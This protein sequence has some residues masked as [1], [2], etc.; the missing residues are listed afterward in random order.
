MVLGL[1]VL[2]SFPKLSAQGIF[3]TVETEAFSNGAIAGGITVHRSSLWELIDSQCTI[4]KILKHLAEG[5]IDEAYEL[6]LTRIEEDWWHTRDKININSVYDAF[7]EHGQADIGVELLVHYAEKKSGYAFLENI[8]KLISIGHS[9]R[10]FDLVKKMIKRYS[11]LGAIE[12]LSS[13]FK[14]AGEEKKAFEL[15]ATDL[16]HVTQVIKQF[17]AEEKLDE[18]YEY[19]NKVLE[20]HLNEVVSNQEDSNRQPLILPDNFRMIYHNGK[21]SGKYRIVKIS[22]QRKEEIQ[23]CTSDNTCSGSTTVPLGSFSIIRNHELGLEHLASVFPGTFFGTFTPSKNTEGLPPEFF[24]WI[25]NDETEQ[26]LNAAQKKFEESRELLTEK[27]IFKN[28]ISNLLEIAILAKSE[29]YYK[30]IKEQ[31]LALNPSHPVKTKNP[32]ITKYEPYFSTVKLAEKKEIRGSIVDV[33]SNTI[34]VDPDYIGNNP[35]EKKLLRFVIESQLYELSQR[36]T[37]INE[38]PSMILFDL[39]HVL[40]INALKKPNEHIYLF[41]RHPYTLANDP[42]SKLEG[43]YEKTFNSVSITSDISELNEFNGMLIHELTH[44]VMDILFHTNARPYETGYAQAE[45][46]TAMQGMSDYIEENFFCVKQKN[47]DLFSRK[48]LKTYEKIKM[49]RSFYEY[50]QWDPEYI[51]RLTEAIANRYHEEPEIKAILQPLEKYW[52]KYIRPKILAYIKEN[53]E[54]DQFI[55]ERHLHAL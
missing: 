45:F 50:G 8:K 19:G 52:D 17:I 27:N 5:N 30:K 33:I 38:T 37:D 28:N 7:N 1:L 21:P 25:K 29:F 53:S 44:K 20:Y 6:A 47:D 41:S 14:E 4:E 10:A 24:G 11:S 39:L 23:Y 43:W 54:Y 16:H 2:T 34:Q 15:L 46:R 13:Y 12:E 55:T 35:H 40:A 51:V 31:F 22:E 32:L 49:V 9:Q 18:A 3:D 42:L 26:K 36:L 48:L